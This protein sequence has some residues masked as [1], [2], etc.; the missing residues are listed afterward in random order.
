MSEAKKT[1][2]LAGVVLGLALGCTTLGLVLLFNAL[3]PED[4]ALRMMAHALQ[5]IGIV[6]IFMG[7]NLLRKAKRQETTA[8]AGTTEAG[9]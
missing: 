3:G 1:K 8:P 4:L 5:V 2:R 9:L 6:N 7:L